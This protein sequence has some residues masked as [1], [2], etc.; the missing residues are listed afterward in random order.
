MSTIHAKFIGGREVIFYDPKNL[1]KK[2]FVCPVCGGHF[3]KSNCEKSDRSLNRYCTSN[4]KQCNF[5]WNSKEDVK[6]F[7]LKKKYRN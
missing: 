4:R 2:E 7:H 6:Y 1:M 5:K 3:Y